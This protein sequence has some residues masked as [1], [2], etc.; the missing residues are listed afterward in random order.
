MLRADLSLSLSA[1][2]E[3]L[4]LIFLE[5]WSNLKLYSTQTEAAADFVCCFF[6]WSR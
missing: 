1:V 3:P 2:Y 4:R 5:A 6:C